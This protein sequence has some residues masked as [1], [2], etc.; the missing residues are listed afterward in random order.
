MDSI[1]I[2][3]KASDFL[4]KNVVIEVDRPLYS[5]HPKHEF[6]YKLNY[7]FIPGTM[8]PDGEELDAYIIGIDEPLNTFE[9]KCVAIIHRLNDDD[10][11]LIVVPNNFNDLAD[12]SIREA[13]YFQE[14][15]FESEI[16][17]K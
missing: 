9:G 8:S 4:G 14:Q 16:I 6:E 12:E 2:I 10:D 5:K 7:G 15:Y 13:T 3:T 17:R 11:K 1:K